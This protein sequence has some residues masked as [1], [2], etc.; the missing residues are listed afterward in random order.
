MVSKHINSLSG[1]SSV[2]DLFQPYQIRP[3]KD[4]KN[5]NKRRF[6]VGLGP[7][8]CYAKEIGLSYTL[9]DKERE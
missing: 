1:K 2:P 4:E 7:L 3:I 9:D 8:Q 6:T 5:V